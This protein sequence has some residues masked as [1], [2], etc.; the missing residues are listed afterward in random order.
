MERFVRASWVR[1]K[2]PSADTLSHATLQRFGLDDFRNQHANGERGLVGSTPRATPTA[3]A[4][5]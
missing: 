2:I 3:P 4:P 5:P 1:V